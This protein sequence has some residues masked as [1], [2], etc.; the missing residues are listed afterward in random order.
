VTRRLKKDAAYDVLR[1]A[2]VLGE[3]APGETLREDGLAERWGLGR[4]PIRSALA[5]LVEDG[6][7]ETKPQSWTRVTPVVDREVRDA[8]QV[9]RSMHEL[10]VGLAVP[11]LRDDDVAEME[12]YEQAFAAAVRTGD[13]EAA[14]AAD[15]ALHD[16]PVRVAGNKAAGATIERF[17]PL[18][19]RLE[20]ARFT[21]VPGRESVRLHARL[22]RACRERD[23]AAAVDV[24]RAIWSALEV[25]LDAAPSAADRSEPAQPHGSSTDLHAPAPRRRRRSEE[26]AP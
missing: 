19:R 21:E 15:D 9:V 22:V 1:E 2:I 10:V 24:T 23:A 12:S 26:T 18:I 16:V 7:V 25:Q 20:R 8:V 17:T 5:R 11:R 14:L 4:A 6:L 3:L 13:V